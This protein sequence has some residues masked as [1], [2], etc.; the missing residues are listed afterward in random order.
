MNYRPSLFFFFF[1]LPQ[2]WS[3]Q[4]Y[5]QTQWSLVLQQGKKSEDTWTTPPSGHSYPT[6]SA[7]QAFYGHIIHNLKSSIKS[8]KDHLKAVW[9]DNGQETKKTITG[10]FDIPFKKRLDELSV[11]CLLTPAV[12][13]IA[14]TA[15]FLK[16]FFKGLSW[17]DVLYYGCSCWIRR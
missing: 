8:L 13:F 16:F 15:D 3:R 2:L 12:L 1:F 7:A 10:L 14:A 17:L 4:V 9:R 6:A 11:N 5:I